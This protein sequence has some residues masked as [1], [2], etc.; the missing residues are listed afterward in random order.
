MKKNL[1]MSGLLMASASRESFLPDVGVWIL[2]VSTNLL[3]ANDLIY[4][5][6][7]GFL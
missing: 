3:S 2:N 6:I 1:D 5:V 7:D 4:K